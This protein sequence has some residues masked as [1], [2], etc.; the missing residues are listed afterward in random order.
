MG[1]Q[2]GFST[3][4][5]VDQTG[6]LRPS[7]T[8]Y[9]PLQ[10]VRLQG[11]HPKQWM[12][13]V[14]HLEALIASCFGPEPTAIVVDSVFGL[15]QSVFPASPHLPLEHPWAWFVR[16][17]DFVRTHSHLSGRERGETFFA[18][19]SASAS[20]HRREVERLTGS[21]SVF[22][23]RPFQKNI[24]TGTFRIWS[25]L[26]Q[27]QSP[28]ANLWPFDL[29]QS[30]EGQPWLFEGYPTWS[31]RQLFAVKSREPDQIIHHVK[32]YG[33][34]HG[35]TFRFKDSAQKE[36][37][38]SPDLADALVLALEGLRS[39]AAATQMD[40]TRFSREEGWILGVSSPYPHSPRCLP[41]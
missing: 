9:R 24:Q 11:V 32:A 29:S 38:A 2:H 4:W 35:M 8:R 15:P 26:G 10:A 14:H 25:E 17:H 36:I 23:T 31:W 19:W 30:R 27:S 1:S 22:Q 37:H 20:S 3:Y 33:Q 7:S 21:N 34:T 6:A 39:A 40:R 28:W 16:A 12:I 18:R 13:S 41:G 5:G